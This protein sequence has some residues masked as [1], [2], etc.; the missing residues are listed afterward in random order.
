MRPVQ[1]PRATFD[2]QGFYVANGRISGLILRVAI[3][4][5]RNDAAKIEAAANHSF[6]FKAALFAGVR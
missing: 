2:H 5:E 3:S 1:D 6:N 4:A